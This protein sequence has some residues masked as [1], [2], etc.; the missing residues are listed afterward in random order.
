MFDRIEMNVVD[1]TGEI[2]FVAQRVFP[3][4]ALPDAA[5]S[6]GGAAFRNLLDAR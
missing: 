5:L 3:I 6:S 2:A 4:A 1:M